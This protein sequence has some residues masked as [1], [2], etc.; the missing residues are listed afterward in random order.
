MSAI[1]ANLKNQV[2]TS[3][4]A[5]DSARTQTL[6]TALS[7]IQK[8]E[9]DESKDLD[10]AGVLK[11]L[12]TLVKQLGETADQ[13]R[14]LNRIEIVANVEAEVKIIKE[15]LPQSLSETEIKSRIEKIVS[16]LRAQNAIPANPGAA[17]GAVMKLAMAQMGSQS[18]GKTIQSAVK[19]A[20]GVA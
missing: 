12:Q 4:K 7:A 17:M 2:I 13:A 15:F 11:V 10:D 1:K 16:D 18:D 9:I 5:R 19:S 6:R 3:M 8:K 14:S 20:L